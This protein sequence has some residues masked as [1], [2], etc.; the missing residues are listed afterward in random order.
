MK[1]LFM[2]QGILAYSKLW[3]NMSMLVFESTDYY[4]AGSSHFFSLSVMHLT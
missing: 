3:I 2:Q 4:T 1:L